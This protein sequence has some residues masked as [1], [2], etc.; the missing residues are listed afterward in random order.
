MSVW[1]EWSDLD[2]GE[3]VE[4]DVGEEQS[5]LFECWG[6]EREI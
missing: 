6:G 2:G 5:P 1:T 4:K 3:N